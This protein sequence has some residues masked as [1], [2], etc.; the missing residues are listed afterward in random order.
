MGSY[1]CSDGTRVSQSIL[2]GKIRRA[3]AKKL[4]LLLE[5]NNYLFC[6]ECKHNG[7][8]TRLDMS[9]NI[10]L[11]KAKDESKT[12]ECWNVNNLTMLCRSCHQK[13]DKLGL[14]FKE[15]E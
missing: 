2:D 9:H 8:G 1:K 3:K 11:K 7:S 5:E 13:K 6:E 10:S 15:N 4:K 12:E 14:K